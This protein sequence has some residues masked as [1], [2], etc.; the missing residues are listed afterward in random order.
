KKDKIS[1]FIKIDEELKGMLNKFHDAI[2]EKVGASILKIS[3]LSPSKKHSF[4]KKEKVRDK[5]FELFM[6]KNL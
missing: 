6:D 3:E 4:E 1:L 2:K 5:E